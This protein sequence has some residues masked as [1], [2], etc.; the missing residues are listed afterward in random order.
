MEP[1][2]SVTILL[3]F[4]P[5]LFLLIYRRSFKRIPPGSLGIPIIGQSL[6]LLRA[7][8]AN[9]GEEWFRERVRKYGPISKLNLF[10]TST[11]FL[12]GPAA[13]KFIYTC[14]EK[15]LANKQ[16]ASIRRIMGE[17]NLLELSGDD[18]KRVRAALVSFLKPETLKLYVGRIDE[19]IRL[20]LHNHWYGN[21]EIKVMPVMKT[22][23]FNVI[24]SLLFG[25]ERGPRRDTLVKLFENA[26]EGVLSVPINLPFTTFN[27]SLKAREKIKSIIMDLIHEKR[28]KLE[29]SGISSNE[30][31]I[32]SLLSMKDQSSDSPVLSDEEIVDNIVVV[33]IAGHDTTSVL[34]TFLIKLLAEDQTVYKYVLKEQEEISK[35]KALEELLSWDDL[36]KMKYTWKVATESLRMN[37]PVLFTFRTVLQ[38]I[39]YGE[40]IIPK[41]WQVIWAS[42]MT[43]MDENIY[44]EPS[45]FDPSRLESQAT[46]P[47]PYSFMAFGGG[48][49]MCPGYEFVRIE[50]LTM[51]HNLVNAFTW[52][53]SLKDNIFGRN[54]M[55]VF[56]QG[57][58]IQIE[59]KKSSAEM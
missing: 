16:P 36:A 6:G 26:M 25:I 54:P 42:C 22:L 51:I 2:V 34:L 28:K 27:R 50:T 57:L 31:L 10:G 14:S 53:L 38:D 40:Y 41:G 37:P 48:P 11:V 3:L 21:N 15:L 49:R 24:C 33:M 43:H 56:N 20:H 39:E 52:K 9:T 55:P 46:K 12:H 35:G 5:L 30:D 47:P 1:A 44:P 13:N 29:I 45:K 23:T 4:L 7:M 59:L 17:K 32:M 8:K 58:P 18:H 19:E